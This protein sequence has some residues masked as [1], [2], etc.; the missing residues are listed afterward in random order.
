MLIIDSHCHLQYPEL[1]DD[2]DQVIANASKNHVGIML[3]VS[4]KPECAPQILKMTQQYDA[5]YGTV[6]VHPHEVCNYQNIENTLLEY[7]GHNKIV[8]IGETGLDLYYE[9]SAYTDQLKSFETHINVARQYT[10]P[11]IIHTRSADAQTADIL[12][13]EM[14]NAE[15]K[16]VIHCFTGSK[17]LAWKALDL[18]LYISVSGILTF[19]NALELQDIVKHLPIDRILVETD[20]P[21][22]A[23]IPFRGKRNEPAFT[24]HVLEKL[25]DL[26]NLTLEEAAKITTDN[27]LRLFSEVKNH[28]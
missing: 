16:G 17:E 11:V 14:K 24:L 27:C 3:A 7:A 19:K 13:S 28:A 20:S 4:V 9:N 6:G 1:S 21:Y 22:L 8:G 5:I 12:T 18:G 26:H 15:F 10:L 2:L 25:A 23:P